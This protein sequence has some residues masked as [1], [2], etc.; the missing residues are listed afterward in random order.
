MTPSVHQDGSKGP[1]WSK[2]KT[3]NLIRYNSSGVYFIR[4]KI[5][6]KLHRQSLETTVYEVAKYKLAES[7]KDRRKVAAAGAA[8]RNGR[9]TFGEALDAYEQSVHANASL[10]PRAKEYR[11]DTIN[12]LLRNWRGLRDRDIKKITKGE[13]IK[14]AEAFG[15]KYSATVYNNTLGTLRATFKVAMDAGTIYA[16]PAAEVKKKTVRQKKLNLP[17][18]VQFAAMVRSVRRAVTW[19][20]ESAAL[21]SGKKEAYRDMEQWS[22]IRRQGKS[23]GDLAHQGGG[24]PDPGGRQ[25][26]ASDAGF[27]PTQKPLSIRPSFLPVEDWKTAATS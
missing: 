7:L 25:N 17:N 9:M 5:G 1:R 22:E 6:G 3:P 27:S 26:A 14:W 20:S 11:S 2:T 24:E 12:C 23:A 8:V 10:K 18:Q 15:Q 13:C 16:N 4:A 19:R 21:L